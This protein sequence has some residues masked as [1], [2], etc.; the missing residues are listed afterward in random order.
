MVLIRI[1]EFV[2]WKPG[3]HLARNLMAWAAAKRIVAPKTRIAVNVRQYSMRILAIA[4]MQAALLVRRNIRCTDKPSVA[5]HVNLINTV[6]Q[7][8]VP[9]LMLN[10]IHP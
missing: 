3:A 4:I 6:T 2:N 9:A 10:A 5:L 8:Q 1:V 7:K